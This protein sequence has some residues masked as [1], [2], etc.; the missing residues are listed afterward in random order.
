MMVRKDP[1]R[2]TRLEYALVGLGPHYQ[3]AA[4]AQIHPVT[5]SKYVCGHSDLAK[6]PKHLTRIARVLHVPPSDIIGWMDDPPIYRGS[7]AS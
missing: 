4:Q 5:F 7:R 3:I 6:H 2:M 1:T